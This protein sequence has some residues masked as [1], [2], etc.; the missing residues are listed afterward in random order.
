MEIRQASRSPRHAQDVLHA[1]GFLDFARRRLGFG[2]QRV[3]PKDKNQ[4]EEKHGRWSER[5]RIEFEDDFWLRVTDGRILEEEGRM[6]LGMGGC[7]ALV[8]PHTCEIAEAVAHMFRVRAQGSLCLCLVK[9][10]C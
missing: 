7:E 9:Y 4:C 6:E 1:F 10:Q 8:V 2:G 3:G 5:R